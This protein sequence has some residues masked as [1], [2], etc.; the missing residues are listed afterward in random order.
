MSVRRRFT[1]FHVIV[2]ISL[3]EQVDFVLFFYLISIDD[4][5]LVGHGLAT[6]YVD[7]PP[8]NLESNDDEETDYQS[9]HQKPLTRSS[10]DDDYRETKS[11]S[12]VTTRST[13]V[14]TSNRPTSVNVSNG[15]AFKMSSGGGIICS[16]C[17]KT[18]YSAEEVKAAGKVC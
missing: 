14:S 1:V 13:P 18:V 3:H 17:S 4:S 16:R 11:M 6:S 5:L 9:Y 10:N 7:T 2:D 12:Y 8:S 15:N